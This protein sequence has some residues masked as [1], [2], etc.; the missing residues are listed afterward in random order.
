MRR[1]RRIIEPPEACIFRRCS[2]SKDFY[3][4]VVV[5]SGRK[6]VTQTFHVQRLPEARDLALRFEGA[7]LFDAIQNLAGGRVTASM[8]VRLR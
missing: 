3:D 2:W 6:H 5:L 8:L 4:A 1:R 7:R